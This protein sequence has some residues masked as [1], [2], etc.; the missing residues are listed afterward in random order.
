[1]ARRMVAQRFLMG[2][3]M[4]GGAVGSV[5]QGIDTL[6]GEQ[7]AIKVL[8]QGLTTDMPELIERF[9]REGEALRRLNHPNIVKMLAM[10]EEE[11]QHYLVM[12]YVFGGSLACLLKRHPQ[13][14]LIQ[15]V[16]IAFE[17]SDAL[18]RAHAA[19][20][21]GA[22]SLRQASDVSSSH[23]DLTQVW[24]LTGEVFHQG[25]SGG[26]RVNAMVESRAS[27]DGKTR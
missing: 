15:V 4:G 1:M 17:L 2:M 14:P 6:S 9:R 11:G 7:V 12:E 22:V 20:S 27:Q 16:S 8:R 10:I 3:L 13:L 24:S 25:A 5:Y 21:A 18:A 23:F 19:L 26:G